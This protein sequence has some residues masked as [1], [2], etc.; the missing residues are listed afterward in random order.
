MHFETAKV[1]NMVK[2]IHYNYKKP[3]GEL[4]LDWHVFDGLVCIDANVCV[5]ADIFFLKAT[6]VHD[7]KILVGPPE[8]DIP[9]TR[10]IGFDVAVARIA[11]RV[12]IQA[13]QRNLNRRR[14]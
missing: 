14:Y 7:I 10:I 11:D 8:G 4:G 2:P 12:R 13:E 6:P 3:P 1:T 5:I 9:V